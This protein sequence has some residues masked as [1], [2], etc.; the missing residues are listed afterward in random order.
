MRFHERLSES[1]TK[2]LSE[3]YTKRLS[4]SY[5]RRLSESYTRR[6]SES[7]PLRQPRIL[8]QP[9][10]VQWGTNYCKSKLLE[11]TYYMHQGSV[12]SV[13]CYGTSSYI[14]R[15][16]SD[17]IYWTPVSGIIG[18]RRLET[19]NL[20]SELTPMKQLTE[21]ST[22][23]RNL[24]QTWKSPSA[25]HGN[26]DQTWK[27]LSYNYGHLYQTE[28]CLSKTKTSIP[29]SE[30]SI[31]HRNPYP[32]HRNL[33]QDRYL[34]PLTEFLYQTRKP[35]SDTDITLRVV[36][37]VAN[38]SSLLNRDHERIFQS[39]QATR[40][41]ETWKAHKTVN[42]WQHK[43]GIGHSLY[44]WQLTSDTPPRDDVLNG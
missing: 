3:S 26:L 19:V 8:D 28:K 22:R 20:L 11:I 6:L 36:C 2:R 12:G 14:K 4:E 23:H 29:E 16:R 38:H 42:K 5:T 1:Y 39:Q 15:G 25:R 33:Y 10:C 27:S 18:W 35:L 37:C 13:S 31:G 43:Y 9:S 24:N 21:I 44:Q 7:Y 32:W 17:S 30:V 34:Y 41:A 40:A